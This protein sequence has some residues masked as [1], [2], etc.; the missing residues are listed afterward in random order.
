MCYFSYVHSV[1]LKIISSL[2]FKMFLEM[3]AQLNWLVRALIHA[4]C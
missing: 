1:I 2:E 4:G 3:T